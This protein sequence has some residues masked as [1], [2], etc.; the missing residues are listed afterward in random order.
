MGSGDE[1]EI[2]MSFL[3]FL[4]LEKVFVSE[5]FGDV[6]ERIRLDG[7]FRLFS[8]PLSSTDLRDLLQLPK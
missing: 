2:L 8:D 7:S 3:L 4:N 5:E 1:L 6:G